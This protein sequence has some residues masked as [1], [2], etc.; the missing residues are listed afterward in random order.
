MSDADIGP[1]GR[2][3]VSSLIQPAGSRSCP[4][5]VE[6]WA[7]TPV[8]WGFCT[9][10]VT[11]NSPIGSLFFMSQTAS[12]RA[13]TYQG[14]QGEILDELGI[15]TYDARRHDDGRF[16][17][18]REYDPKQSL[19]LATQEMISYVGKQ[20]GDSDIFA[21]NWM[22]IGAKPSKENRGNFRIERLADSEVMKFVRE[23]MAHDLDQK[24]KRR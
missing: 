21:G 19:P 3:R 16:L 6:K 11:T 15:S 2:R 12:Q 24:L 8:Y 1:S 13:D 18:A 23:K 9:H 5:L 22:I 17:V 4:S 10:N 20:Q 7:P 14:I